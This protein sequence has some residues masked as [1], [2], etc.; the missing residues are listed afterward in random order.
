MSQVFKYFCSFVILTAFGARISSA[1]VRFGP[2]S[3]VAGERTLV[4]VSPKGQASPGVFIGTAP[5]D[6]SAQELSP[7][8]FFDEKK[9]TSAF[10]EFSG[11]VFK[12]L[13]LA[14]GKQ[15]P[16][17]GG[18]TLNLGEVQV[19]MGGPA[20][21]DLDQ[22]YWTM[23]EN[24]EAIRGFIGLTQIFYFKG[25]QYVKLLEANQDNDLS[26]FEISDKG[27]LLGGKPFKGERLGLALDIKNSCLDAQ[28]V[29]SMGQ[30]K[31]REGWLV[32]RVLRSEFFVFDLLNETF[33]VVKELLSGACVFE[34]TNIGK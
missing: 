17:G 10:L 5:S 29:D 7:K 1:E 25:E 3:W 13:V 30:P 22:G 9:G 19:S 4:V 11:N 18:V 24:K 12:K 21:Q 31:D 26:R 23:V 33:G 15:F 2:F 8:I 6:V 34:R 16:I 32:Y 27:L 28:I 20:S 14:N